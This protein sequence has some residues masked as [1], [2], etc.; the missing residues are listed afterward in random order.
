M[1]AGALLTACDQ[2]VDLDPP[3]SSTDSSTDRAD[4]AQKSL[5]RLVDSLDGGSRDDAVALAA[6]GADALL[7]WVHDNAE[8]LRL[9]DLSMRYVDEGAPLGAGEQARFGQDAW[10]GSVQLAYRYEGLD[11]SP[12]QVETSAVFVPGDR[13][14]RIAGFGGGDAR[15]PLWLAD[16]LSVVR[17]PQTLL[18]VAGDSA[19]RYPAL[20]QQARRQVQKVLP[21]WNGSLVVEVPRTRGQLDAAVRAKPGQYDNI[22]AVTTSADGSL[23]QGAPVRVFVNPEVFDKLKQRGAQVVM[24]HE[25]T[26]VATGATFVSMPTWLLEGFADF[27]A[28]DGAGVPVDVAAGQILKRIRQEGLPKDLP[29]ASDLDPT[30]TGLGATYEEAWLACRFL[31]AEFGTDRLVRFYREVSNGASAPDAF[32]SVVGVSQREFVRRWRTDLSGLAGV[33][34]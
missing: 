25:A 30:A 1:L 31:A 10:R 24:S 8:S 33:A 27:V 29:T 9:G 23:A 3:K 20:V 21:A 2:E 13:G 19:G 16:R 26:H 4:A 11:R 15:V 6:P 18:A 32:R 17:A 34:P 5:D 22:A 14:A 7:G 28:L 12:A